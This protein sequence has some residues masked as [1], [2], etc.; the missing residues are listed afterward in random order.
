MLCV[1]VSREVIQDS[2]DSDITSMISHGGFLWLGTRDGYL[3]VLD[4]LSMVE[5]KE[6]LLGLQQCGQGKV[7]CIVPLTSGRS[8]LQAR[9]HTH[10]ACVHACMHACVLHHAPLG[11]FTKAGHILDYFFVLCCYIEHNT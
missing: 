2:T 11:A 9:Y 5:R 3:I 10:L 4:S 7:K 8:K 6:P 1:C